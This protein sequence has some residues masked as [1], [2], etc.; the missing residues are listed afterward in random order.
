MRTFILSLTLSF[1]IGCQSLTPASVNPIA[2]PA[3]VVT[4]PEPP[5]HDWLQRVRS[6]MQLSEEQTQAEL[7]Q[8]S[9]NKTKQPELLFRYALLNQQLKDRLGWIR[10]RDS[11]QQ[12]AARPELSAE[13]LQLAQLLQFHNQSMINADARQARLLGALEERIETLHTTAAALQLSQQQVIELS[14]KIEALT[15]LEENMSIRRAL[16][17]EPAGTPKK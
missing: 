17:S 11:L 5:V 16:T 2:Q 7:Q 13:Q 3:P 6:T 4:H 10:A 1:M 9:G 14:E 12:L 8:F 15:N